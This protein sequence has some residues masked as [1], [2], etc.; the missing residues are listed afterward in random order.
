VGLSL[1]HGGGITFFAWGKKSNY[2]LNLAC[3]KLRG[4]LFLPGAKSN[5]LLNLACAKLRGSLF[6]ECVKSDFKNLC[7]S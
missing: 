7:N 2:L 3:A 4:S 1:S 6:L 5:Y